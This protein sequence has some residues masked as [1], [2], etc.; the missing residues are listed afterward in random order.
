[1]KYPI[2]VE[3]INYLTSS[4]IALALEVPGIKLVAPILVV[5]I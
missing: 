4:V 3:F 5:E 2:T 1:M